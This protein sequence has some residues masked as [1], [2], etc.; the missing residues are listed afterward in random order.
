MLRKYGGLRNQ[1][2][3]HFNGPFE[4]KNSGSLND[5][6][7]LGLGDDDPMELVLGARPKSGEA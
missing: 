7:G 6:E 1:D 2:C 3:S 4:P 5:I